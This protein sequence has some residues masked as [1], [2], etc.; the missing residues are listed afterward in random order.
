MLDREKLL[1][2]TDNVIFDE[3]MKKHTSFRIGGTADAFVSVTSA[4]EIEKIICFCADTETP[5]MI[6]GNGSN[7]LVSDKGIRG[8]V[9]HIGNGMSKC[10]IE[11]CDVYAD[12]GILMSVLSK[13]FL[14]ANLTGFEFA[15]GI[16]GTL[17]GGIFMNAGAYGGELK[18]IIE[19]VTFICPDGIIKTETAENLGF[20]YRRSMFTEGGYVI[21]SCK[22]RLKEGNYEDI[23]AMM[24]DFNSRRTEKQP[25]NLPS[26][27]S[28][29][30]RPEGY[31]AGKLIQD[32]GLM[33]YSI[34]GAQVSEKH[35]G[36]VVNTGGAS[37]ADVTNL[38]KHIQ[39]T[40]N[41]KFGV[42]LEP[43]VRLAGE[44]E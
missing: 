27:G 14:E 8:V 42:W 21:L 40:V 9:I 12:A 34:G 15:S 26:A 38:I 20:A 16:P 7:I 30:K 18:D 13:K 29:F 19:S 41:E 6:M 4:L 43:E 23:K 33:G 3:D 28:T 44:G 11:G 5:Y 10:R 37:A 2:I 35:A 32:A 39:N 24:A 22:L 17:G 31:F 25:L 36:F 1:A